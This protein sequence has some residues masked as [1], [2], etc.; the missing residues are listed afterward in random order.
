MGK[1]VFPDGFTWGVASSAYQCEGS[2][3]A[4]GAAPSTW[5]GFTH[6]HGVIRD[7]TNGDVACDNY[8]R[9]AEDIEQVRLLGLHAYRF[10]VGWSRIF[11][12]PG[13]RN[14]RGLDHYE[15]LVDLLL[16]AGIEPWLTVFHLDEPAWLG[17]FTDRSSV[18]HLVELGAALLDR[19]GD[20]VHNWITVNEPTVYAYLGWASGEFPPGRKLDLRG[21]LASLHHLLL[22]HARLCRLFAESGR[23]ARFGLAHHAPWVAPARPANTRDRR[24]AALMDDLANR[25]VLDPVLRGAWPTRVRET[26]HAFLPARLDDDLAEIGRSAGTYIGINYYSRN[27]YRWSRFLPYL[28]A[29]EEPTPGARRSAMWE[30]YPRGLYDTLMRLK[31]DYGNPPCIVT[32][33]G[34]PLP[35]T[36]G[37]DPLDDTERVSYL[38]GHVAMLARAIA[39]GADCRGYFHWSLTDNFEWNWGLSMRFGLVHVDYATQQRRWKKSASWFSGLAQANA[40]ERPGTDIELSL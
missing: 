28:H 31:Q 34:F 23:A 14:E 2:P 24:A 36:P 25:T 21:A 38:R 18:D 1:T 33:N 20:R 35:E 26:L 11:P 12:G 29:V 39:D 30:I 3:L 16:A 22:G 13:A 27:C 7:G 19:L 6:R 15:R 4:D 8:R 37:K 9:F 5:H 17:G 40:L 10:S 32:E